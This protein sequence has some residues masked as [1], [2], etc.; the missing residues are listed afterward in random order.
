MQPITWS[1]HLH[2]NVDEHDLLR[3]GDALFSMIA[4]KFVQ[5]VELNNPKEIFTGTVSQD[6]EML[7]AAAVPA[8]SQHLLGMFAR[9]RLLSYRTELCAMHC[10]VDTGVTFRD[11]AVL[12]GLAE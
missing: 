10:C 5:R 6:F 4:N 8:I 2:G 1:T 12:G 9:P 11:F 3:A 7:D